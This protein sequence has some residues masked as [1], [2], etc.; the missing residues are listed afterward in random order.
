MKALPL[1]H[2]GNQRI[3][4]DFSFNT[5]IVQMLKQLKDCKWSE[6]KK[7]WHIPWSK[8]EFTELKNLFPE[9]EYDRQQF[10][11]LEFP[12]TED[13]ILK[14]V[15]IKVYNRK[16]LITLPKN[17]QDIQIIN[18]IKY[19]RWDVKNFYWIV[20][21]YPG[22]L[23]FLKSHF[24][25][26]ASVSFEEDLVTYKE[27]KYKMMAGD[28]LLI[29][30]SEGRL[31]LI[32]G[33]DKNRLEAL[34]D[35]PYK[36]W[37]KLNK[38]WTFPYSDRIKEV[39][40]NEC[41]KKRLHLIYEEEAV[42]NEGKILRI[43][44]TDIPNYRECPEEY[45]MKLIEKR[46][47]ENTIRT[48]IDL[49]QE[50]INFHYKLDIQKID[51]QRIISYI[52]YLVVDRKVSASYQNQAINA[53]KFYYEKVLGGERKFYFLNRPIKE[54]TLPVVLSEEEVKAILMKTDN[55]KH[56]ALLMIA[57]SAGLRVS[58]IIKLKVEDID[59]DRMQIRVCQAKGK[60][61]RYSL[62]SP[63]TL[64]VLREYYKA[65]KPRE[66]LFEGVGNCQYS[67]RSAQQIIRDSAKAAKIKKHVTM[68]TL[69]HSFAT[70][71]LE[72]G[73]DIRY[74]QCLLGHESSKT[75]E[76]YT[77]ITTKGMDKIKSPLDHLDI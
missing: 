64:K 43:K 55:I 37:D 3:R 16:I 1:I 61:D 67:V 22:N 46:Y 42:K 71:L 27:N 15:D 29:K 38:W 44:N 59:S 19:S 76:I 20:P 13:K 8:I 54:K 4:I 30:T 58:E 77:H 25:E 53:I 7:C 66:W 18:K 23:D 5:K 51:E 17:D 14:P 26:R 62:L 11:D 2:K 72:H 31:K 12:I 28:L 70:H 45:K 69:R 52:R 40:S 36:K 47:S 75:T 73:T 57:Y 48:Y 34:K 10:I 32:S 49:F 74:I 33:Y 41:E 35:I 9:I 63:K 68:H 6:T 56:K 50:F 60:K 21:N 65:Y 24:G 39:I